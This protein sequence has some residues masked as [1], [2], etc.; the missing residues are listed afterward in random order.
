MPKT[1]GLKKVLQVPPCCQQ[2]LVARLG[3]EVVFL[4]EKNNSGL[5]KRG[6][7]KYVQDTCG[8]FQNNNQ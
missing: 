4:L 1:F 7:K 3:K 8:S 5:F 6:A 2:H